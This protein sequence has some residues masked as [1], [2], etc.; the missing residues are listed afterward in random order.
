V[1]ASHLILAAL[2]LLARPAAAE[3]A[4]VTIGMV[5]VLSSAASFIALDKGYFRDAGIDAH[6]ETIDTAGAAMMLLATD[7][8]QIVEGGLSV[9]LFNSLAQGMPVAL[10]LDRGS[11]PLHHDLAVRLDLKDQI[12][13]IADLKRRPVAVAGPGS[14][15]IYEVGKVLELSGLT[16]KDIDLKN[17]SFPQMNAAFANKAIDAT[18]FVPPFGEVAVAKGFAARWLDPDLLIKPHP[19]QI[20]VSIVNTDWAKANP[21]VARGV[22]RSVLRGA[23]EFCQAYHH[24]PNRKE[25]IDILMSHKVFADRETIET[26]P[27]QARDPDGRV[28]VASIADVQ[29]WFIKAGML[30]SKVDVNRLVANNFTEVAAKELGPFELVNKAS[31]LKGC[32][33]D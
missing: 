6:L 5:P 31:P 21:D 23:R 11:S 4:Q 13:E 14:I 7:R 17:I 12:K 33:L 32:R 22:F 24:G 18:L 3:N 15:A 30:N 19:V 20:A 16:L 9:G 1:K 2:L 10:T 26:M 25:V 8:M 28:N 29:D 27:W